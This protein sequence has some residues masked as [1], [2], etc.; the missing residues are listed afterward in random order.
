MT[1]DGDGDDDV[2]GV[3]SGDKWN[4][5]F[6]R[7]RAAVNLPFFA[8]FTCFWVV[9]RVHGNSYGE[10]GGQPLRLGYVQDMELV[11]PIPL[12]FFAFLI[13]VPL[14]IAVWILCKD[15]MPAWLRN[16][17]VIPSFCAAVIWFDIYA[18]ELVE[19]LRTFGFVLD[20]PTSLLGVTILA[21]GNSIGDFFAD[22]SVARDGYVKMAISGCF[23]EPNFPRLIGLGLAFLFVTI[24]ASPDAYTQGVGISLFN[25]IG[26][27]AQWV[28]LLTVGTV[29]ALDDFRLRAKVLIPILAVEYVVFLCGGCLPSRPPAFVSV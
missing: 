17:Y 24:S 5:G 9:R 13:C 1:Y 10:D 3:V 12:P 20:I 6:E 29:A 25:I 18:C 2:G 27:G 26:F 28:V 14:G 7:A 16:V 11:G 21:W 22:R 4:R 8:A 15:G 23:G 19:C